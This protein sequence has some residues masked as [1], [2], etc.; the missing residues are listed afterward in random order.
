MS[1][2]AV[3]L[4]NPYRMR[5]HWQ[6]L[7]DAV[8]ALFE[9]VVARHPDFSRLSVRSTMEAPGLGVHDALVYVIP[10]AER[11]LV[12]EHFEA[13]PGATGLTAW[14]A[15][16]NETGSEVYANLSGGSSVAHARALADIVYHELLH[17]RTHWSDA[18]LHNHA[19]RGLARSPVAPPATEGNHRLMADHLA[20][21]RPQWTGGFALA[22]DPLRGI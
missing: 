11:T 14:R 22:H 4:G 16:P 20:A 1:Q 3:V 21:P 7:V 9:P 8:H 18:R 12:A 5:F 13:A 6:A 15:S 10:D 17:N 19:S 2:F